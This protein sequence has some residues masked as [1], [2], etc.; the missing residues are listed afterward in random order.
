MVEKRVAVDEATRAA[1]LATPHLDVVAG[2][3][4]G[5]N[6]ELPQTGSRRAADSSGNFCQIGRAEPATIHDE[7]PADLPFVEVESSAP[8]DPT[9]D[10]DVG[11]SAKIEADLMRE[12]LMQ[13]DQRRRSEA[14]KTDRVR[15]LL[16]VARLNKGLIESNV[17][18]RAAD[19][20]VDNAIEA[21]HCIG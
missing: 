7:F 2:T 15:D 1:D 12:N 13:P 18:P 6:A 4:F 16:R 3:K 21:V 14:Q 8:G 11:L 19:S 10:F 17:C 9:P 5:R 20:S